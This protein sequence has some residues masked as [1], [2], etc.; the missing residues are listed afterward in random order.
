MQ[1]L[2]NGIDDCLQKENWFGALFIA[3]TLPDICGATED[4]VK[5]NG[6]RYKDWFNRYLKPRYNAD[7]TYDFLCNVNPVALQ[8]MDES[9]KDS[10]RA[11]VPPV[12]FSAEDCWSL[13]NACLH[14]G[15]DETK[16]RKFKITTPASGNM[17]AHMNCFDGVLQL[18]VIDFCNDITNGVKKWLVDIQGNPDVLE[19]IEKMINIDSRI[20]N[21]FI[22][23]KDAK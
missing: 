21:G 7:S 23:C 15:V 17:H 1:Q 18:D 12:S 16:L 2:L 14:E 22:D 8:Y 10:L 6:A 4:K 3:I 19:K 5:G 11:Q 9:L 13:R 20:F